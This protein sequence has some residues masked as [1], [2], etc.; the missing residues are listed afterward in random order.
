MN[1][2]QEQKR[3]R[4]LTH[5]DRAEII[6][7]LDFGSTL[8]DALVGDMARDSVDLAF[9]RRRVAYRAGEPADCVHAIIHGRIKLCRIGTET[10]RRAVI[11]ILAEGALFGE[12]GLY[13]GAGQRA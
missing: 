11:D 5:E 2:L 7:R 10:G 8:D 4:D 1:A 6:R 9:G 3:A 13:P 12:S